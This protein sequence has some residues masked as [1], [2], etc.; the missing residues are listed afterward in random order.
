MDRSYF[1]W[2][3]GEKEGDGYIQPRDYHKKQLEEVQEDKMSSS[4]GK[5]SVGLGMKKPVMLQNGYASPA[6][7]CCL[8]WHIYETG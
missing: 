4:V 8:G 1:V 5:K 6:L 3:G 2:K 7:L